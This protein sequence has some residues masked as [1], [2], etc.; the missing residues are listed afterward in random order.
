MAFVGSKG[1]IVYGPVYNK[2]ALK[3]PAGVA[4]TEKLDK[5]YKGPEKTL[6]RIFNHW[7]ESEDAAKVGT[8]PSANWRY[9][10]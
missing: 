6:S 3:D 2:Q 1:S 5:S 7:L 8:Q 9:S 4:V 10:K